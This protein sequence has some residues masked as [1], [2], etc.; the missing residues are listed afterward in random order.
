MTVNLPRQTSTS[1]FRRN[2]SA[3]YLFTFSWVSVW[4]YEREIVI[5][6]SSNH[7]RFAL[8]LHLKNHD[9]INDLTVFQPVFVTQIVDV[10]GNELRIGEGNFFHYRYVMIIGAIV[11]CFR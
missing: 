10:A 5:S 6:K 8:V 1:S 9:A 3:S 11:G 4:V 7:F 2:I